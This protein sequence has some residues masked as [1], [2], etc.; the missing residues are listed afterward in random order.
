MKLTLQRCNSVFPSFFLNNKQQNCR[1]TE[2]T[3]IVTCFSAKCA[4]YNSQ[5]PIRYCGQCHSIRHNNRCGGDHIYHSNLNSAWQMPLEMQ[6]YTVEAIVSL[7]KEAQPYTFEKSNESSDR[8]TRAGLWLCGDLDTIYC[9]PLEERR[10][11]SRY[12]VWLL[13]ALARPINDAAKAIIGRLTGALFH[14]FD[15]TA[16]VTDGDFFFFTI[17]NS[18][19]VQLIKLAIVIPKKIKRSVSWSR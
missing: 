14:W 8:L 5:K 12:G 3:A 16:Y 10:L 7:L 15:T 19:A 11:L 6:S 4:G 1:S 18:S 17:I 2:K 13:I 9:V